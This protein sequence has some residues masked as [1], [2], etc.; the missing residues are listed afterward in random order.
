M[1]AGLMP[2]GASDDA[3]MLVTGL[4]AAPQALAGKVDEAEAEESSEAEA[5]LVKGVVNTF[6]LEPHAAADEGML[7]SATG[8]RGY[9]RRYRPGRHYHRRWGRYPRRWHRHQSRYP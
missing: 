8:R 5:N 7:Q 2:H 4:Q 3:P 1:V 6:G 9:Y